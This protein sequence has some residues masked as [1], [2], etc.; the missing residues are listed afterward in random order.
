[1]FFRSDPKSFGLDTPGLDYK[2][3]HQYPSHC[4]DIKILTLMWKLGEWHA[5]SDVI[6][7]TSP[8]IKTIRS[9]TNKSYVAL[10]CFMRTNANILPCRAVPA[11]EN[12]LWDEKISDVSI[13]IGL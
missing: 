12:F 9:A 3:R 7:I 4:S 13:N 5:N 10:K 6:S 11:V 8:W 2:I 1:M